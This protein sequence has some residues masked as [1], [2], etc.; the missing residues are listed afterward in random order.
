[1]AVR[2]ILF[3]DPDSESS[4][5]LLGACLKRA[6]AR[7]DLQVAA[8][9]DTAR[10]P[11]SR[12]RLPVVLGG[13]LLRGL[14]N[15]NT[16]A[17]PTG[18]PL[19]AT[20]SA[21][22]RRHRIP[23]LAPHERGVNDER[24]LETLGRLAPDATIALMVEQ[25]FKAPLL[26]ACARP[27]N[28]HNGLLPDY[29][30]VAATGW[31]IY[32]EAPRSGFTFHEM[33]AGID[34]GPILLQGAVALRADAVLARVE[35]E[36]TRLAASMID[37]LFDLL[38]SPSA[39]LAQPQGGTGSYFSR[40]DL[41]AIRLIDDPETLTLTELRRRLR[42]FEKLE[43]TIGGERFTVTEVRALGRKRAGRAPA[44]VTAD[45]VRVAASRLNHLP[46]ALYGLLRSRAA[47]AGSAEGTP[48]PGEDRPAGLGQRPGG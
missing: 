14:S 20:C 35:R 12:M 32:Q 13:R 47:S 42:A 8:V 7:D 15:L 6:A 30:G 5:G 45:G 1:M 41:G 10:A 36:K 46:P 31:S 26:A 17:Q 18:R 25:I 28:Y 16:A 4:V 37:G 29:R 11:A 44:F 43:L 38:S 34:A 19:L 2:L 22:A 24:F 27:I 23:L 3:V 33:T 48:A 9:V 21:H 40:A 39:P